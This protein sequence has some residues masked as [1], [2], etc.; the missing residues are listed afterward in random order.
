VQCLGLGELRARR[1][2]AAGHGDEPARGQAISPG[3]WPA[4]VPGPAP[5]PW[6]GGSTAAAGGAVYYELARVRPPAS[7]L[8]RGSPGASLGPGTGCA[9]STCCGPLDPAGS[10]FPVE[11]RTTWAVSRPS[12]RGW[13]AFSP[14]RSDT[15]R[16][17]PASD[18]VARA[19][20]AALLQHVKLTASPGLDRLG[21]PPIRSPN[22]LSPPRVL[23]TGICQRDRL[24]AVLSSHLREPLGSCPSSTDSSN[25]G[26]GVPCPCPAAACR[27]HPGH[28][29]PI[30]LDDVHRKTNRAAR[31]SGIA[32]VI[33]LPDPPGGRRWENL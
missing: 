12:V 9:A 8:V 21:S 17:P 3:N 14:N 23:P 30:C 2:A 31:R 32:R 29:A 28:P 6:P 5:F 20:S 11:P 18:S 1:F 33:R 7:A 13:P 16:R 27:C 25:R 22:S 19:P 26:G 24:P 4:H 15:K 10:A